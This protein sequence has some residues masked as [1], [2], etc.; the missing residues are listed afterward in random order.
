MALDRSNFSVVGY[1]NGQGL[2]LYK[3]TD[4][5]TVVLTA[6]YFLPTTLIGLRLYDI[7]MVSC[8]TATVE[9]FTC[10][11]SALTSQTSATTVASRKP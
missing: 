4:A 9:V 8:M 3:T 1:A 10:F 2:H 6:N 5:S 7:I 11:I